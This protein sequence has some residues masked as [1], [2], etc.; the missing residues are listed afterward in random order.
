MIERKNTGALIVVFLVLLFAY[1]LAGLISETRSRAKI[2][3]NKDI[4]MFS[5]DEGDSVLD[6]NLS[7][8]DSS[9]CKIKASD[10]ISKFDPYT[11]GLDNITIH[12]RLDLR[13]GLAS[14]NKIWIR[15]LKDLEEF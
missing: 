8:E 7:D 10:L 9:R 11:V 3:D 15:C 12:H 2:L 1:C 4:L 5:A 14:S 13:R 6:L